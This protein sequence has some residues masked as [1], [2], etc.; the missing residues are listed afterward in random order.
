MIDDDELEQTQDKQI[1]KADTEVKINDD[2]GDEDDDKQAEQQIEFV[3]GMSEFEKEAHRKTFPSR[4]IFVMD[5]GI[6]I[7][8]NFD[9]GNLHKAFQVEPVENFKPD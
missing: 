9:S 1:D 7:T 3:L 2:S 5:K 4:N 6:T 8:S